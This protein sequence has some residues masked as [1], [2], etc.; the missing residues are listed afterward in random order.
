MTKQP[1]SWWA[2]EG[3]TRLPEPHDKVAGKGGKQARG[4]YDEE[5]C[6][7]V[8]RLAAQAGQSG[9]RALHERAKATEGAE[10]LEAAPRDPP[11]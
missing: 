3:E 6:A 9:S 7:S 4:P 5:S 2:V 10:I 11:A 8:V 1:C